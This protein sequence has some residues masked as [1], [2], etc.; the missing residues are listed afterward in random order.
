MELSP[1]HLLSA[2]VGAL[3][4]AAIAFIAIRGRAH[5]A[6]RAHMAMEIMYHVMTAV[7]ILEEALVACEEVLM[8]RDQ[9][10]S[11]KDLMDRAEQLRKSMENAFGGYDPLR[12]HLDYRVGKVMHLPPR[13][14][15]MLDE[16]ERRLNEAFALWDGGRL[17]KVAA[18]GKDDKSLEEFDKLVTRCSEDVRTFAGVL[19]R[20]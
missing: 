10:R 6:E 8:A 3:V 4:G 2:L 15:T 5:S 18:G 13:A 1:E 9:G 7:V 14:M 12:P 20:V 17:L 11:K 16:L 19:R